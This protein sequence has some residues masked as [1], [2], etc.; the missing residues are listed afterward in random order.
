[1]FQS[2][3][4]LLF[5]HWPV[6]SPDL[7]NLLPQGL[8]LDTYQGQ[9]WLGIVPFFMRDVRPRFFPAV[10][11]ISN[12][13]ELNVR[14]YIYDDS[15]V[16]GVWFFSLD[17]NLGLACALGRSM[18][19]LPYWR[20]EMDSAT[21]DWIDYTAL[22]HGEEEPADYRYRGVGSDHIAKPG[23]LEFFL[24]E[25]YVLYSHDP[26]RNRLW[27]GRVHHAPYR[28]RDADVERFSMAPLVW[29][30]LPAAPG[31][32]A[33]ACTVPRVDVAIHGLNRIETEP[34]GKSSI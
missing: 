21:G 20:A 9:A 10:P 19:H 13:M 8:H 14:T 26:R 34:G 23:S 3:Q 7:E 27:R 18:F 29:G 6:P 1:M 16:P 32:P 31:L 4:N 11:G 12:F 30:D 33:H 17:A 5:L 22:R 2:W 15:G 24:L 25:R 28:F